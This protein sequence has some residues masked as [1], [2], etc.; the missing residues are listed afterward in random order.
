M[1]N[2]QCSEMDSE[3]F[4]KAKDWG[5]LAAKVALMCVLVFYAIPVC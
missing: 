1:I 5:G 3:K 4:K 2:S